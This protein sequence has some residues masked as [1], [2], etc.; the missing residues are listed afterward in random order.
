MTASSV[1]VTA[2]VE[3][4][5]DR[6]ALQ[7]L[8]PAAGLQLGT[9]Y[10]TN[11]KPA[12]RRRIAGFNQAAKRT[13]WVVLVDLNNDTTCAAELVNTLIPVRGQQMT[14]RIVVRSLEAWLLADPELATFLGARASALPEDP[15]TEPRPKRTLVDLARRSRRPAIVTDMV[16][17]PGSGR[18]VGPAFTSRLIEFIETRWDPDRAAERSDSLRRCLVR[19]REIPR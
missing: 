7:R 11:G 19:L 12:M 9:V 1:P 3:G 8:A 6:A 4:S 2:A 13:P 17:R 15:E 14:L 10:V 18:E 5:S 16:P